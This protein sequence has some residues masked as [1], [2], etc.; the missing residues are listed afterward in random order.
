MLK[1]RA[2]LTMSDQASCHLLDGLSGLLLTRDSSLL[3]K[4]KSVDGMITR[5]INIAMMKGEQPN[6]E[7]QKERQ[8]Q[9][10]LLCE[11]LHLCVESL[12]MA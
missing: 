6:P 7:I 4:S 12:V 1:Q 5:E 2:M 3:S 8:E 10:R 11:G 9:R